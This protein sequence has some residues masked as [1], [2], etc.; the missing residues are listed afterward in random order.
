MQGLLYDE[1]SF[2]V[3]ILVTGLIGGWA[4]WM[5]GRSIALSWR[6][7]PL[8]IAYLLPLAAAV[9]FIHFA[10]FSSTL[11]SIH[12]YIVDYIILLAVAFISF[13]YYKTQLMVR[14]YYWIIDKSSPIR[15]KE[16]K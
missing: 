9:R 15:W 10:L 4:A 3:F 5:T 8:V 6:S 12:L 13:R 2:A 16:Q 14:Q 11:L 7:F 1:T